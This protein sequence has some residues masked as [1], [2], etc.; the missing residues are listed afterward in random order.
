MGAVIASVAKQSRD[1]FVVTLLAMTTIF[2]SLAFSQSTTEAQQFQK[3][4]EQ[5]P[6]DTK[7]MDYYEKLKVSPKDPQI[8]LA[9]AQLFLER[10]LYELAIASFRRALSFQPNFASAHIG[11]SQAYRKKG[12]PELEI[13][14]ME[15][16]S[17]DDPNNLE[18][19][20]Q[21]GVLYM[22]PA[23]FD[24]KKA[25]KQYDFLKKLQSPLADQLGAKMQ[26]NS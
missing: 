6:A 13:S 24:Y 10:Q 9:L 18:I 20:F 23:H 15:A 11:L 1:C 14:E 21:L 19:R 4:Q 12:L 8:H 2:P 25:K 16:A 7:I 3:L 22:E 26:I 17:Q 5:G